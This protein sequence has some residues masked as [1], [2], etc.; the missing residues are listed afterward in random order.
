MGTSADTAALKTDLAAI[1]AATAN[2]GSD[3][4]QAIGEIAAAISYVL[5]ARD[6]D[7]AF[8]TIEGAT[9]ALLLVSEA[10]GIPALQ[11]RDLA[12]Q[13]QHWRN[14]KTPL[15]W[16]LHNRQSPLLDSYVTA[17]TEAVNVAAQVEP[18]DLSAI[19]AAT[20]MASTQNLWKAAPTAL[21]QSFIAPTAPTV[22][23]S[24][25]PRDLR[26]SVLSDPAPVPAASI[27]AATAKAPTATA[28]PPATPSTG[29]GPEPEPTLE[30]LYA[31][32]DGLVGLT[33]V[34]KLIRKQAE[35]LRIQRLRD[36][37]G[38]ADTTVTRHLMFTG[39]PGT[40]KS[41]VARLVGGIYKAIGVLETGQFIETDK[42]GLVA[43]YVGQTEEKVTAL[44]KSA[45]GGVLFIDEAYAL[46]GDEFGQVAV[47]LLVKAAEDYRGSLV[48][49]FAGY[50]GP[51]QKFIRMNP[52]LKDRVKT[53]IEFPDYSIEELLTIFGMFVE[54]SD[55]QCDPGVL[56][57]VERRIDAEPR[58]ETFSNARFVRNCFENAL[59]EHSWR[60]RDVPVPT[61]EQLVTLTCDDVADGTVS[62][63]ALPVDE[64]APES[65]VLR[66]T[67]DEQREQYPATPSLSAAT[68]EQ[69][70]S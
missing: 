40:G 6:P 2:M 15:V 36:E 55:Y 16:A 49:I 59:L 67:G 43:G 61:H 18:V 47:D 57:A 14:S 29:E 52:G 51:M 46:V 22:P 33:D 17:F 34:K 35:F 64:A 45:I 63:I 23:F 3:R 26:S 7:H 53:A 62:S 38:L 42:A 12:G 8:M 50:T 27:D 25:R 13:A 54:K 65:S 68:E 44:I 41:T 11:L 48:I 39:N 66:A 60:L 21:P 37:D 1:F 9:D 4:P 19:T 28:V 69:Q 10:S 58:D 20:L 30:E 31:E 5:L 56:K 32:L 70:H 24:Y